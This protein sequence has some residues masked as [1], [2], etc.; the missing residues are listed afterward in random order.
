MDEI[1]FADLIDCKFPYTNGP[2]AKALID[3]ASAISP[4]AMFLVLHEL[5]R[6]GYG[7]EVSKETLLKLMDAWNEQIEHP[8]AVPILSVA[9]IMANGSEISVDEAM[10]LMEKIAPFDGVYGALCIAYFSCDDVDGLL[11]LRDGQIRAQWEAKDFE[12]V[13]GELSGSAE[14]DDD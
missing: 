9:R 7:A 8:L 4:A 3:Q 2:L 5:C 13:I 6:P 12:N 10:A 1:A 11:D 14:E